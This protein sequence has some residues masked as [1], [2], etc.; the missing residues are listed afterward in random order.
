M[1]GSR[2]HH[3]WTTMMPG[4]DPPSGV[5][6]YPDAVPPLLANST[7]VPMGGNV[8]SARIEVD[9]QVGHGAEAPQERRPHLSPAPAPPRMR[10]LPIASSRRREPTTLSV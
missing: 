6:R 3:S 2:P 7:V 9:R 10:G 5:T 1:P 8:P 4:P